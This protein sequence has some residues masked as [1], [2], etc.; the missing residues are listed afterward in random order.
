MRGSCG[1]FGSDN[2][3]YTQNMI[4]PSHTIAAALPEEQ[5]YF[6]Y[7]L[8][9]LSIYQRISKVGQNWTTDK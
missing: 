7:C 3:I 2:R 5:N 8:A 9:T 6:P 4:F 1:K